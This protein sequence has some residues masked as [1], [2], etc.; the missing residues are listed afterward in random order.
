MITHEDDER[1]DGFGA[2]LEDVFVSSMR[3]SSAIGA[4]ISY[5]LPSFLT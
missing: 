3:A 4:I 2:L 1:V 5:S